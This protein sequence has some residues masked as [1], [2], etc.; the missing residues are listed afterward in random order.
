LF[1]RLPCAQACVVLGLCRVLPPTLEQSLTLRAVSH[2]LMQLDS[3]SN[4]LPLVVVWLQVVQGRRA[5]IV[6]K[7][8]DI[9]WS[10]KCEQLG[11]PKSTSST[12]P[13]TQQHT[14][15]S[16]SDTE[17]SNRAGHVDRHG[18]TQAV[19]I[20][21]LAVQARSRPSTLG[22]HDSTAPTRRKE[23]SV[24]RDSDARAALRLPRDVGPRHL[25]AAVP[26]DHLAGAG[27][28]TAP[29]CK[30]PQDAGSSSVG[31]QALCVLQAAE[32]AACPRA[33]GVPLA[34]LCV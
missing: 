25:A 2:Y 7:T 23:E 32:R 21:G 22:D 5:C 17:H 3:H 31:G 16:E 19:D 29:R 20:A 10:G 18:C 11:R 12:V 1:A 9:S 6:S 28:R 8:A 26:A 15:A 14:S 4:S 13:T 24:S 27:S 30:A 34:S 33:R